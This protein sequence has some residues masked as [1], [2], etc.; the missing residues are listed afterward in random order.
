MK[1]IYYIWPL[2]IVFS[3]CFGGSPDI[4][5]TSRSAV[6]EQYYQYIQNPKERL[7]VDSE[8]MRGN[9]SLKKSGFEKVAHPYGD[10]NLLEMRIRKIAPH[11]YSER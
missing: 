8:W 9:E 6:T 4:Y 1:K 7:R 3:G 10:E 5:R 11:R 2:C